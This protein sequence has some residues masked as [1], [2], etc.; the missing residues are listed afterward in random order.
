M[1]VIHYQFL[2]EKVNLKL[3]FQSKTN[4]TGYLSHVNEIWKT[5]F[6][7]KLLFIAAL[8]SIIVNTTTAEDKV[9]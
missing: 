4:K 3:L 7:I 5:K 8:V 2:Q 6:L 1:V 9:Q